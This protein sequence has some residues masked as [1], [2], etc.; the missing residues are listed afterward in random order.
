MS[1]NV[2]VLVDEI[3]AVLLAVVAEDVLLFISIAKFHDLSAN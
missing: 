3:E 2:E 1:V